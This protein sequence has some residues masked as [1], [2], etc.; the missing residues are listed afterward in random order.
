MSYYEQKSDIQ[1]G[2]NK[3]IGNNP[4]GREKTNN[5]ERSCAALE[6]VT[7]ASLAAND[8]ISR[9]GETNAKS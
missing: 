4:T 3:E 7:A 1:H 2:R 8:K 6:I 9:A 5:R